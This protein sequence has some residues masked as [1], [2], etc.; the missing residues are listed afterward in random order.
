MYDGLKRIENELEGEEY[1][2]G[3]IG[4]YFL[5]ELIPTT[6]E[7]VETIK[8]MLLR[9]KV[10]GKDD[11]VE[12]VKIKDPVTDFETISDEWHFSEQIK[13]SFLDIFNEADEYYSLTADGSYASYGDL[14]SICRVLKKGD[15]LVLLEFYITD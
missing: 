12:L 13:K 2:N 6:V 9:N 10:I 3:G 11:N 4:Y 15:E 1:I 8:E 5:C 14:W 7:N